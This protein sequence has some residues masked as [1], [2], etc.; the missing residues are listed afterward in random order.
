MSDSFR[1]SVIRVADFNTSLIFYRDKLGFRVD[2]V[3]VDLRVAQLAGPK[4]ELLVLTDNAELNVVEL[5]PAEQVAATLI[6]EPEPAMETA[7]STEHAADEGVAA[8]GEEH[9]RPA[10]EAPEAATDESGEWT[11]IPLVEEIEKEEERREDE[12]RWR[13]HEVEPGG[14]VTFQGDS[15][16]FYQ[17][18]LSVL[19]VPDLLLEESPGLE[20]VLTLTDPDGYR[21]TFYESL[22]ISDDELMELYRKGPD[23]LE[24][25]MLGLS[26]EDLNLPVEE[27]MT[28]RQLVLQ[29]VDFDLEM[30]QRIKWALAE[31]GRSYPIPLY[32]ADEWAETLVYKHRPVH[33]ELS[34]L[35]LIRDHVLELCERVENALDR[36]LVSEQGIVEVRTMMQVVAEASREQIQSI[37]ET[38][39][40]YGK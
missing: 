36:H 13:F 16:V 40:Q 17:E 38:R 6:E 28:I 11:D 7:A 1:I 23:L 35:R 34:M 2:W 31:S 19:A 10:A 30:M 32:D 25:A 33:V 37:L 29:I 21:V 5:Y 22:R 39:H 3:D 14:T 15:L 4:E 9:S 27:E 26:D 12:G 24:G 18:H 8:D 20:Q